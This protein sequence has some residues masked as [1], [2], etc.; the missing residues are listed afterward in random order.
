MPYIR[1]V[2]S[3]IERYVEFLH[4]GPVVVMDNF[5]ANAIWDHLH[6]AELNFSSVAARLAEY[7]PNSAYPRFSGEE[8]ENWFKHSDHMPLLVDL[9]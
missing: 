4:Q 6:P 8:C 9:G 5:N 7:G 2:A 1:A 3:A